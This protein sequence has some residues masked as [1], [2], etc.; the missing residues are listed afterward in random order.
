VLPAAMFHYF[1]HV[2]PLS[3]IKSSGVVKKDK[4]VQIAI[5]LIVQVPRL[6][7][8]MINSYGMKR[9][10]K[11]NRIHYSKNWKAIVTPEKMKYWSPIDFRWGQAKCVGVAGSHCS[12][13]C[14]RGSFVRDKIDSILVTYC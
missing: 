10:T 7:T 2:A 6:L 1:V 13:F 5:I 8:F 3:E 4:E 11:R 12:L 14:T 9:G